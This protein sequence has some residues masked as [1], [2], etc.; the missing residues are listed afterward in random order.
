MTM[1]SRVIRCAAGSAE[2]KALPTLLSN[3]FDVGLLLPRR[4]AEIA[5]HASRFIVHERVFTDS[6]N[7]AKSRTG[8]EVARGVRLETAALSHRDAAAIVR[9]CS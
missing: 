8:S 3:R 5:G 4:L 9:H 6:V 2:A 1:C 7:R